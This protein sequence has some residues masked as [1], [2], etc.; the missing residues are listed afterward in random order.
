M[1][2]K[3]LERN[4]LG[5]YLIDGIP[6]IPIL[7]LGPVS[8]AREITADSQEIPEIDENQLEWLVNQARAENKIS[9]KHKINSYTTSGFSLV[10]PDKK[11][12]HDILSFYD[13]MQKPQ[14]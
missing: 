12:R 4:H 13:S 9:P 8:L 7:V 1:T 2:I 14:N 10:F 5:E 3:K 6:V 11:I